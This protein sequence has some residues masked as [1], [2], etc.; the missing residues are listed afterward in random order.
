M[1]RHA[2]DDQLVSD[3]RALTITHPG[4]CT[5][6]LGD[7]T[8]GNE[9]MLATTPSKEG[10]EAYVLANAPAA[11]GATWSTTNK[12]C[13]AEYGMTGACRT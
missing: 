9:K 7:G 10:C 8:G 13:Y 1:F 11:N 3:T 4:T 12:K 5:F 6:A 2:I